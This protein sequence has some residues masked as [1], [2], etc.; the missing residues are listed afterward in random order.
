MSFKDPVNW[1]DPEEVSQVI[2]GGLLFSL[3]LWKMI[4]IVFW[5]VSHLRWV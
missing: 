2:V 4:D 1:D 3:A 5:F